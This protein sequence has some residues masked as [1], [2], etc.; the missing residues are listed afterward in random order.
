MRMLSYRGPCAAGGVS[1]SLTQIFDY[2]RSDDEWWFI[3][4][5]SLHLRNKFEQEVG[6]SLDAELVSKHYRYCNNYLWPLLHDLPEFATYSENER[7]AYHDFNAI[8]SF[9]LKARCKAGFED[10]FVNDYQF[11]ITPKLLSS[12]SNSYVFW[13]VPWPGDVPVEHVEAL[14]EV[15]LGLLGAR[16]IGFHTDVYLK[17][18]FRFVAC[19]LPSYRVNYR[20]KSI[21]ST[22]KGIVRQT[23]F[24]VAPLGIDADR[25]NSLSWSDKSDHA[26]IVGANS[27]PYVLSVDRVDYT[28]GIIQRLEAINCFFDMFPQWRE[29]VT[30][31]QLGTRSRPGL[32]PFDRYWEACRERYLKINQSFSSKD[33]KPIIWTDAPRTAEQVASLYSNANVMLVSPLRDGLNLTAKEFVACQK[34]KPGVLALSDGAGVWSE[35]GGD[36]VDI[37]PDDTADFAY[38]ISKSLQ[39]DRGERSRRMKRMKQAVSQNTLASWWSSFDEVCDLT[40]RERGK[41]LARGR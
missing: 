19:H 23:Q 6:F 32:V 13:H 16:V 34:S 27:L 17:N 2:Q 15:A 41:L 36:C 38:A 7:S 31:V 1:S 29:K 26:T 4:D 30:F 40:K 37:K 21:A 11:A 39:M 8:V 3:H 9:L 18:F 35:I 14:I 10:C 12:H 5:D 20:D 33:W 24:V 28:K 22:N 25:W